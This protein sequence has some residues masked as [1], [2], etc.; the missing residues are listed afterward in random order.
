[1]W[2]IVVIIL[3]VIF[4][5]FFIWAAIDYKKRDKK[6]GRPSFRTEDVLEGYGKPMK[7]KEEAVVDF[8]DA[9]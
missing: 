8:D 2:Y 5:G 6:P 1:M 4:I 9:E 7:D 3:S